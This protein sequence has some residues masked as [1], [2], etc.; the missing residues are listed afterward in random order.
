MSTIANPI[1]NQMRAYER[2]LRRIVIIAAI[3]VGLLPSLLVIWTQYYNVATE[4]IRDAEVLSVVVER[5]A[6]RDPDNW[7][8]KEEYLEVAMRGIRPE[9]ARVTLE[10]AG[11]TILELGDKPKAPSIERWHEITVQGQVAGR[12]IVARSLD[13]FVLNLALALFAALAFIFLQLFVLERFV[14]A[15]MRHANTERQHSDE[16]LHDLVDLSSDWFW[17]QDQ[18]YRFTV[19]S[20]GGF[21]LGPSANIIGMT[22]WE[23]P[24]QLT[25]E[26][27]AAHRADLAAERHFTLRYPIDIAD[28]EQHWF[29][30]RGKPIY[31]ENGMFTGYRGIGRNITRAVA[32]EYEII[33]HRDHLQE[34]VDVQLADVVSAKQA[35]EAAN[36]AKSE[37]LTNIS[38]ELRTPMHGVLSFAKLGLG[39]ANLSPEKAREYFSLI[40]QS[41]ERLLNLLNDLLDLSKL[42]AGKMSVEFGSAD[43]AA[44]ANQ[45][46]TEFQT[47]AAEKNVSVRCQINANDTLIDLDNNRIGQLIR[48]LLA[49]A[50]KFSPAD[51]QIK[52]TLTHDTITA[53]LDVEDQGPGVAEHDAPRIFE[54]FYRSSTSR[55]IAGVGLGLAIAREFVLAHRGE[56]KLMQ[57][58]AGAHFRVVLP[59]S[60]PYLRVQPDA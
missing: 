36:L 41:G 44:T 30:I 12:V 49:N 13:S 50:L 33:Q 17:E 9:N 20:V 59:L 3:L 26:Q 47:L 40:V 8:L 56:I 38:H 14:F 18:H 1:A 23:L 35:A 43:L 19:N 15:P 29:E 42:E 4:S 52:V 31:A 2:L 46:A 53:I 16:R 25:E 54:P 45:V 22:R 6:A 55:H 24:I 37:F 28:S 7:M 10:H 39:K 58:S 27:W 11:G 57:S 32:A 5:Y 21:G 34:M 48:N 51:G 60:A